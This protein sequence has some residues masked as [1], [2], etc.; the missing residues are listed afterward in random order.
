MKPPKDLE[1]YS[2]P[3]VA[4]CQLINLAIRQMLCKADGVKIK[5]S[6]TVSYWD[7]KIEDRKGHVFPIRGTFSNS[8]GE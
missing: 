8:N 6:I 2:S 1:K 3:L 4:G 7:E 5:W